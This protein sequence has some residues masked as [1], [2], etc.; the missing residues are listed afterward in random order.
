ML[1]WMWVNALTMVLFFGVIV[2]ECYG[3]GWRLGPFICIL[4][5]VA[6]I[7][8]INSLVLCGII[9]GMILEKYK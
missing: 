7:P 9:L 5:I 4:A 2:R 8:G 3:D 6:L 1:L